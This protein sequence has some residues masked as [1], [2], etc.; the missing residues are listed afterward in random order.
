[1]YH[2]HTTKTAGEVKKQLDSL[3]NARD[4]KAKRK[5]EQ[6]A[7]VAKKA[8]KKGVKSEKAYA[9]EKDGDDD[10]EGTDPETEQAEAN[11]DESQGQEKKGR[12]AQIYAGK[13]RTFAERDESVSANTR[14]GL[15]AGKSGISKEKGRYGTLKKR[16]N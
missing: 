9:F 15:K 10:E 6:A 2:A 7:N 16:K 1:M 13:K 5:A 14:G 12:A 4:L 11:V 3:K 8:E